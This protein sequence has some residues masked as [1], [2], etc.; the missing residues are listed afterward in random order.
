MKIYIC[1]NSYTYIFNQHIPFNAWYGHDNKSWWFCTAHAKS[2]DF[3]LELYRYNG[4]RWIKAYE[5]SVTTHKIWIWANAHNLWWTKVHWFKDEDRQRSLATKQ[6][7]HMKKYE[8]LM[9]HS[10]KQKKGGSGIRLDKEN[11]YANQLVTDYECSNT[12]IH[13][14]KRYY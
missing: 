3:S 5:N 10:R 9:K 14:F 12:P 2:E 6:D 11:Y 7:L 13:D 1:N 8:N 4:T